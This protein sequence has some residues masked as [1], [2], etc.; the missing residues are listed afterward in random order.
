MRR[1]LILLFLAVDLFSGI[2]FARSSVGDW[3]SVQDIPAG[4]QITVVTEFTFPCIFA[5]ATDEE[6]ICKVAQRNR[7]AVEPDE[8]R[9]RRDRIHEV[10]VE[11]RDG[12]NMLAGAG[13]AGS[14][15]AI[16]GAIL[17]TGARGPSAY[18]FGLGGASM[19]ARTGRDLHLLH[20]KVIYR[21]PVAS[22]NPNA[23]QALSPAS[24]LSPEP[25]HDSRST[26]DV[27][28][29]CW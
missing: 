22:K 15:G 25:H 12:A 19:G 7:V 27:C 6:L 11:R 9:V 3:Q 8:I 18:M 2:A 14:L 1:P 13:G 23:R 20:G 29:R 16:L 5:H 10:R 4:W 26:G 17:V 28:A 21:R 24:E